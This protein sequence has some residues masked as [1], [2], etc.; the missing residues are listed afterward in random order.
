MR[1]D[2]SKHPKYKMSN[3]INSVISV[4]VNLETKL[5][6]KQ[7]YEFGNKNNLETRW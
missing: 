7:K 3:G 6:W 2:D 5:S 1:A 4:K